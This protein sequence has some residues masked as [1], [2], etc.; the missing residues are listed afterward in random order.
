VD[1][2]YFITLQQQQQPQAKTFVYAQVQDTPHCMQNTILF[3][4]NPLAFAYVHIR[5]W[6]P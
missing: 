3:R 6:V 1:A 2:L 5:V 4:F